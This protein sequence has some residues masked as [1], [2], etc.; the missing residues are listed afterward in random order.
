M[1]R[2]FI[3]LQLLVICFI[4][5]SFGDNTLTYLLTNTKEDDALFLR[6]IV[7]FW[8]EKEYQIVKM[9]IEEYLQI[10]KNDSSLFRNY[11][12]GLLGDIYMEEKN[13]E[14]AISYYNI[15][16]DP[17]IKHKIALNSLLASYQLKWFPIV[18]KD[19]QNFLS[20][21]FNFNDEDKQKIAYLVGKALLE[22]MQ[23]TNEKQIKEAFAKEAKI[24]FE[25]ISSSSLIKSSKEALALICYTLGDFLKASTIYHDLAEK[26]NEDKESFLFFAATMETEYDKNKAI[27][28]FEEVWK[29]QKNKAPDALYNQ[30]LLF[31]QT[32]NYNKV[33]ELKDKILA[34]IHDPNQIRFLNFFIGKSYFM[35]N[36]PKQGKEHL[37]IFLTDSKNKLEETK[38][39]LL[40]LIKYASHS[41][42]IPLFNAYFQQYQQLFANDDNMGNILFERMMLNK[43]LKNYTCA[44]QDL[45]LI[46]QKFP[47]IEQIAEVCF[48][49]ASLTFEMGL[50]QDS[51]TKFKKFT[52]NFDKH[53][54]NPLAWR[55]LVNSYVQQI[56]ASNN[57]HTQ[58]ELIITL[59]K[60]INKKILAKEE[61]PN[62][63]LVLA[64][65]KYNLEEYDEALIDLKDIIN[66]YPSFS[67]LAQVYLL[68]A[69]CSETQYKDFKNFCSYANKAAELNPQVLQ[70]SK[71]LVGFYNAY[72][73]LN[74]V[75][76]Q[77]ELIDKAADHLFK[78]Y[79]IKPDSI[80]KNNVLWL[81]DHYYRKVKNHMDN[82]ML[83]N[84][85]INLFRKKA[86]L[87]KK[88]ILQN[89]SIDVTTEHNILCLSHLYNS[90]S[91]KQLHWLNK[92]KN[93]Y[94]QYPKIHWQSKNETAFS[95][96]CALE[97]NKQLLPAKQAF[98]ALIVN[99]NKLS[100]LYP[101]TVLHQ[102]R[103]FLKLNNLNTYNIKNKEFM[104]LL[105]H[106]KDVLI[107]KNVKT[108]PCH[109]EAALEYADLQ[110]HIATL[111]KEEKR[112]F[113]LSRIESMFV[114]DN[115]TTTKM[116]QD[117]LKNN[118][119][120]HKLY[121]AY[122]AFVKAEIML[123]KSLLQT[124][125]KSNEYLSLAK[126]MFS[127]IE[128]QNMLPTPYL[129]KR[130]KNKIYTIQ[131][132]EN[133]K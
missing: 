52:D 116:Y 74:N 110:C 98:D 36:N 114:N 111:R 109:L 34:K 80:S 75:E 42:D 27:S 79:Q 112:L 13:Y 122:I 24:C 101:S 6:R 104:Q 65:T 90:N 95:I 82:Y 123:T 85:Q 132:V 103:L 126:Q 54:L 33:I 84:E 92:L 113:L 15:I 3:V 99:L 8:E 64:Q 7:E 117:E 93:I 86:V 130:F 91:K 61:I 128:K 19:G 96:A 125:N 2:F 26:Y 62:Y 127:S 5:K 41:L 120:K 48:E 4:G 51:I 21:A 49:N 87:L 40:T 47:K 43:K 68:A 78:A 22:Q 28:S 60:L 69:F 16:N 70:D 77:E 66:K 31:F 129:K 108:E 67:Q 88:N 50:W 97:K 1:R 58:R 57:Q 56:N 10:N 63:M 105:L 121:E 18:V 45:I 106:L 83:K 20:N 37:D 11:L 81:S 71:I 118:P 115:N 76:K 100:P 17:E 73:K 29:I 107:N 14:Q 133:K 32:Q 9:Q 38:I 102:T 44:K 53:E 72:L 12:V 124:D 131:Y 23:Q 59:E 89:S 39:A 35:L 55:Y 30:T 25:N 94:S 119:P 46:E